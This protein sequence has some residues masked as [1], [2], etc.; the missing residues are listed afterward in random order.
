MNA[1]PAELVETPLP[2]AFVVSEDGGAVGDSLAS[3]LGVGAARSEVGE[4]MCSKQSPSQP[5]AD[6]TACGFMC[7]FAAFL[8]LPPLLCNEPE[9]DVLG[10]S[11]SVA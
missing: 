11:T 3:A 6:L 4:I 8:F 5:P 7:C 2:L 1:L 10:C 9:K